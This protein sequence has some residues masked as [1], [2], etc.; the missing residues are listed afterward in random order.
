MNAETWIILLLCCSNIAV[1]LL[2]AIALVGWGKAIKGWE[3]SLQER[4]KLLENMATK[5]GVVMG[6][7]K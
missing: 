6:E 2:A 1:F 5:Y 3:A 7:Q 4:K